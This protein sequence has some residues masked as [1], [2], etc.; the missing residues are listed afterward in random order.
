M[1]MHQVN[2]ARHLRFE[3]LVE[4]AELAV[5]GPFVAGPVEA[6]AAALID[7][8]TAAPDLSVGGVLAARSMI[9]HALQTQRRL[10]RAVPFIEREG[11]A[12]AALPAPI[13]IGG[14]P[15][16]G[17]TLLQHLIAGTAPVRNLTYWQ[18]V[19]PT[20]QLEARH[21]LAEFA[22][23]RAIA[24][25]EC[26]VDE[27]RLI[28]E[29]FARRPIDPNGVAECT[30]MF[31]A[32]LDSFEILTMF[33][34]PAF[35]ERMLSRS[36]RPELGIVALQLAAIDG[37]RVQPWLLKSLSFAVD[38]DAV[39]TALAPSAIIHVRRPAAE[40]FASYVE[41]AI[42]ARSQTSGQVD[43]PAVAREMLD[44]WCRVL[45][46]AAD[47][48]S[49]SGARVLTVDYCALVRT[50]VVAIAALRAQVPLLDTDPLSEARL[51]T[52]TRD[53]RRAHVVQSSTFV[54]DFGLTTS[55]VT[56]R[57]HDASGGYF[58]S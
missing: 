30:P 13:V 27:L 21:G 12:A 35:R 20:A 4:R 7:A 40:A 16:S 46:R 54:E 24:D 47:A 36:H 57:L 31:S 5:P 6:S 14:A 10:R 38:Y 15:R 49:S 17:T 33:D 45:P 11:Y 44:L 32:A 58:F 25:A 9:L 8:L 26:R 52:I 18:A 53:Q 50:P 29:V 51:E 55:D 1:T 41:L 56:R 28:E 42:A 34:L 22:V 43:A 2:P 19:H 48:L 23:P 3:T 37:P 39:V